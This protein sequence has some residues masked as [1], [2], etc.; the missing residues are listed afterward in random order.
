MRLIAL[1]RDETNP[2]QSLGICID[3][4]ENHTLLYK[5][6]SRTKKALSVLAQSLGASIDPP[7][8]QMDQP[9][10]TSHAGLGEEPA[11]HSNSNPTSNIQINSRLDDNTAE[12]HALADHPTSFP[13]ADLISNL[14]S[15]TFPGA[16]SPSQGHDLNIG[17]LIDT[18]IDREAVI[19]SFAVNAHGSLQEFDQ[20]TAHNFAEQA[21]VGSN[22]SNPDLALEEQFLRFDSLNSYV[23]SE[24]QGILQ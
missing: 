6:A 10:P 17:W 11:R 23:V 18:E 22:D 8:V 20:S 21:A 24:L 15:T 4:L 3:A 19:Q 14:N 2:R 12:E 5:A 7:H 9:Q 1:G 13:D 16:N